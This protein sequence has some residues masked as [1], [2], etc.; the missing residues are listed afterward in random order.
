MECETYFAWMSLYIDNEL[1][2]KGLLAFEDH[3]NNCTSCQEELRILREIV[4]DMSALEQIELPDGFHEHLMEKIQLENKA[5]QEKIIQI[6]RN[7]KKWYSNWRVASGIAA[8]FIF[9][10]LIFETLNIDSPKEAVPKT[11]N[12]QIQSADVKAVEPEITMDIAQE[13]A[14]MASSRMAGPELA[15][16]EVQTNQYE[17]CKNSLV[18][19]TE[20]MGLEKAITENP[21]LDGINGRQLVMEI[22]LDKETKD[23]LASKLAETFKDETIEF[24]ENDQKQSEPVGDT[25]EILVIIINEIE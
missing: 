6:P 23:L 3:L 24:H 9:S 18:E 13:K 16:W 4:K 8:T 15:T 14:S 7:D 17:Q 12:I 22:A 10:V 1:Q 5:K 19:I 25:S 11:A 20:E 2:G 21:I